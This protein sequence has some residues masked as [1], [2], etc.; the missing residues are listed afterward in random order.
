MP[1]LQF[2]E[3]WRGIVRDVRA[4]LAGGRML[5]GI[6]IAFPERRMLDLYALAGASFVII[7]MEHA[8]ITLSEIDALCET[9]INA[10]LAPLVRGASDDRQALLRCLDAG[11]AGIV[12]PDIHTAAEVR[13]WVETI[14]YPPTGTRGL[15]Q[16]RANNW[17]ASGTNDNPAFRPLLVPMIKSLEAIDNADELFAIEE[18]DWY[19]V[20]LVDLS[21]RLRGD[22]SAPKTSDLLRELA[23]RAK[24]AGKVLGA[25]QALSP[26]TSP[27]TEGVN[28]VAT[29]DRAV[30]LSGARLFTTGQST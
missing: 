30:V 8:T 17:D 1:E 11:A 27:P 28:C 16:V 6:F 10:G 13:V 7:D 4:S 20:G 24:S 3:K 22:K 14:S 18:V 25:N 29:P 26:A 23:K 2:Q 12:I 15:S 19:H 5:T 21:M 9:A